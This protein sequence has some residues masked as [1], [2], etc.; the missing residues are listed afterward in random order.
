MDP[1]TKWMMKQL[2]WW[3][4]LMVSIAATAIAVG[5]V[6]DMGTL[7]RVVA[8]FI[9]VCNQYGI[10][11]AHQKEPPRVPLADM[12]SAQR[13]KVFADHPEIGADGTTLAERFYQAHPDL[14]LRDR[15][16]KPLLPPPIKAG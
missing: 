3:L 2:T 6:P 8:G 10:T 7:H 11:A 4:G 9:A 12:T 1:R 15:W 16:S 13:A 5:L 14:A